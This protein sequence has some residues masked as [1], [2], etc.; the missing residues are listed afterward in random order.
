MI[1]KITIQSFISKYHLGGLNNHVKWRIKDKTLVVYGGVNGSVCKVELQNFDF[2]DAELGIFDT[3]KLN[4]LLNIT[5][6]D[7]LFTTTKVGKIHTKLHIA[8]ASFDVSYT[9]ADTMIIPKST[10]YEDPD[11]WDMQVDLTNEDINGLIKA[12]SALADSDKMLIQSALDQE[13]GK[14]CEFVFGDMEGFSDKISYNIPCSFEET[15]I[16]LPFNSL[17]FR[18]I[19]KANKDCEE[20]TL[21]INKEGMMKLNFTNMNLKSEY[22]LLRNE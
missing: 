18:D 17:I 12:K 11:T 7:L 10:Y 14:R 20:A 13:G 3:D 15:N 4:K 21:R 9:L 16:Q 22:F 19:L 8:D 6:G 5:F 2:E 1:N